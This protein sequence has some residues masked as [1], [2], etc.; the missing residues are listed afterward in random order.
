MP[1][2]STTAS[3]KSLYAVHASVANLAG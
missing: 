2:K 3:K 1:R